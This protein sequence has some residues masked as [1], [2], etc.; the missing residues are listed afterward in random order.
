MT[1]DPGAEPAGDARVAA[2]GL[3]AVLSGDLFFGMRIRTTLRQLGY[4]VALAQDSA[5]FT[6]HLQRGD[7]RAVLG[8]IDF[9]RPGA[10]QALEGAIATGIPM[11]AFGPH[12]DVDGFRAARAA[13]VA[14][15][16]ANGEFSNS[17]AD[18]AAR[19]AKA[20]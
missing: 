15:T 10:W 12:T 7:Q 18:L 9:N 14:R 5:A 2:R 20:N 8:L 17:L 13:G 16:I 4:T 6:N 11:I 1:T 3:V 19:Y